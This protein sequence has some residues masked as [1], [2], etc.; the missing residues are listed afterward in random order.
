ML[1]QLFFVSILFLSSI[2]LPVS[3]SQLEQ[4]TQ[5][6]QKW[7]EIYKEGKDK[8]DKECSLFIKDIGFKPSA[9]KSICSQ[10][11]DKV[12]SQLENI[13]SLSDNFTLNYLTY[14]NKKHELK[15]SLE[16]PSNWN[17]DEYPIVH[18]VEINNGTRSFVVDYSINLDY[19]AVDTK[20]MGEIIERVL[21]VQPDVKIIKSTQEY[22]NY[23]GKEAVT[24]TYQENNKIIKEV[25]VKQGS[26]VYEFKYSTLKENFDNDRVIESLL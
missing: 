16:Y 25:I 7:I 15:F 5:F 12:E 17:I 20:I 26:L 21:K 14:T 18:L 1:I 2:V 8:F 11:K 6:L 13:S 22:D 4:D 19:E 10:M 9:Q 3:F 24:L 23:D